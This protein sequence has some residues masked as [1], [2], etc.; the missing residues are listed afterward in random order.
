MRRAHLERLAPV[1]PRCL[2]DRALE[3]A[4]V[5]ARVEREDPP[6]VV[7][8]GRLLCTDRDCQRE[9][10]V[11]DGVPLLVASLREYV[12]TQLLSLLGREDLAEATE[13]L[14]GDGCGPGSPYDAVRQHLSSYGWDHYGDLDPQEERVPGGRGAGAGPRCRS[15][16]VGLLR[17][18]LAL[19]GEP[20]PAGPALDLGCAAGRAAFELAGAHPG[21]EPVLGLDLH[22]ALLRLAAGVLH[23]GRV[24]YPRRRVGLVYERREFAVQLRGAERVGFWAADAAVLPFRAASVALALSLNL[25]DCMAAP[26]AHL[27]ELARVLR[28]G[29][30]AVLATPYDWN[31]AAT[32]V[33]AWLGGHSQRGPQA[34]AS[35]PVLRAL[36]TP[37]EHPAAIEGLQIVAERERLP[38]RV[39][40]HERAAMEYEV[41]LVVVRRR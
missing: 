34:G 19:A 27:A 17:E 5:L 16:V 7:L 31:P 2:R 37:G 13:S 18:A 3:R 25:L 40:M 29:G 36:L 30:I 39:R 28:A 23:R 6:G 41:H 9:Y 20:L 22:H 32:P 24:R 35:E 8:E 12:S 14:L 4:L 26:R 10:P 38:W 21:L 15:A 33:E 1:C 11:I